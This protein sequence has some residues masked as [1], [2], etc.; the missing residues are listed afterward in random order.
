MLLLLLHLLLMLLLL[1]LLLLQTLPLLLQLLLL[2]LHL[3]LL[4][5]LHLL[6]LLL[7]L[8]LTRLRPVGRTHA[9]TWL[10]DV[11]ASMS[12]WCP[13]PRPPAGLVC[14][15]MCFHVLPCVRGA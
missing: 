14:A 4:P 6:L 7:Q 8:L 10:T 13:P 12:P 11:Q 3:L 2:L 9:A 1:H 5:L 15:S